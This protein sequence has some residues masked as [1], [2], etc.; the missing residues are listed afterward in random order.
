M[1]KLEDTINNLTKRIESLESRAKKTTTSIS[2]SSVNLSKINTCQRI[3]INNEHHID[4]DGTAILKQIIFDN[5]VA[6]IS[7]LG[8]PEGFITANKGSLYLRADGGTNTT[9]YVKESGTG[10]NG[11]AAK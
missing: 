1:N 6:I 8:S 7:G 9:L 5:E 4:A 2:Q 3:K 10:S 11:W